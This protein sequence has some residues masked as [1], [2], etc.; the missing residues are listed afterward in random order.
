M[1]MMKMMMIDTV[2][3]RPKKKKTRAFIKGLN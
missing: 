2:N 3:G 1:P